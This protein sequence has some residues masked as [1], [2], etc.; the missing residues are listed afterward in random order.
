MKNRIKVL[1]CIEKDS[2]AY[3]YLSKYKNNLFDL[4]SFNKNIDLENQV[5]DINVLIPISQKIDEKILRKASKLVLIQ[6]FGVGLETIN[7][8]A[9]SKYG[10]YVA[11]APVNSIS[12]AELALMFMLMLSRKY[13]IAQKCFNERKWFSPMGN[14]MAKKTLLIIGLGNI[15]RA[16][17][18]MAKGLDMYVIGVKRKIEKIE[19]VDEVY[20]SDKLEELLPRADYIVIS[21]PLTEETKNFISLKH[22]SMMKKTAYF[23]NISRGAIVD[24]NALE[25]ALKEGW[26]AGAALDVFWEEPANPK[27]EIYNLPNVLTTPHIGGLTQEAYERTIKTIVENIELISKGKIP[28]YVVNLEEIRRLKK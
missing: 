2:L 9:V 26:I 5:S 17:A 24:K 14:E 8:N 1:I 23:I 10:I 28:K 16:L 11:I 13:K 18:K 19:Y 22:F 27:E 12:V 7:I 20:T 15:G 3:E 21:L 25:K 4:I 6:Q